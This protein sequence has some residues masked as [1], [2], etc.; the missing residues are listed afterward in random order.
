MSDHRAVVA[1]SPR[2][3]FSSLLFFPLSFFRSVL[4]PLRIYFFPSRIFWP[5]KNRRAS[6]HKFY[7]FPPQQPTPTRRTMS[8]TANKTATTGNNNNNQ[9]A[10]EPARTAAQMRADE[11]TADL[12]RRYSSTTKN[13]KRPTPVCPALRQ[14]IDVGLD[15]LVSKVRPQIVLYFL[16]MPSSIRYSIPS[17]PW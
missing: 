12:E 16:T 7:S 14:A 9:S 1:S 11:I 8:T 6:R 10:A 2:Q 4:P 5:Q 13:W 3:F 17:R 15:A